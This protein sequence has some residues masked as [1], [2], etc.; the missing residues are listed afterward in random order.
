LGIVNVLVVPVVIPDIS[1]VTFLVASVASAKV[2]FSNVSVP[3]N[4]ANVPVVGNVTVVSPV[5]VKVVE[6]APLVTKLLLSAN[7]K[8]APVA[9]WVKVNLFIDVAVATPN[10]G[11][12]KVGEVAKTRLPEPVSSEITPNNC[13]DVVAAN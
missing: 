2:L 11:V 8:V 9:G 13:A 5:A 4:V 6:K 10:T 1:N 12:T 3:S 7:V